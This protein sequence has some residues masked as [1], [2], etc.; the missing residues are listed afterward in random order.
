MRPLIL[1][2]VIVLLFATAQGLVLEEKR[3]I[4]CLCH[5]CCHSLD[6]IAYGSGALQVAR[7]YDSERQSLIRV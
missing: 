6:L 7:R 4:K 2:S 5:L 3:A 1:T